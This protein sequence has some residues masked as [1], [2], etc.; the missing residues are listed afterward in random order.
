MRMNE[1]LAG[2]WMLYF[3]LE[4][5]RKKSV[6]LI[7]ILIAFATAL[8]NHFMQSLSSGGERWLMID[9]L[10]GGMVLLFSLFWKEEVGRADGLC[11]ML[12]GVLAGGETSGFSAIAGALLFCIYAAA[13]IV[14]GNREKE[15][16]VPFLPFLAT[17]YWGTVFVRLLLSKGI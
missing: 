6:P 12:L 4:D 8:F 2:I 10:P 14:A 15:R 11:I 16:Q 9:L 13:G 17:G 5:C 7:A 3:A 1:V